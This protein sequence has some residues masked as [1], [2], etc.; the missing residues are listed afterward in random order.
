MWNTTNFTDSQ[1]IHLTVQREWIGFG[2]AACFIFIALF[3]HTYRNSKL[4][5]LYAM[6]ILLTLSWAM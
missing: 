4:P 2:F 5:F 1:K 3:I 6:E